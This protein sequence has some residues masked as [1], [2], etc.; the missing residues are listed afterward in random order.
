[1]SYSRVFSRPRDQ[2]HVFCISCIG[3]W[4]MYHCATW[5]SF[6]SFIKEWRD[7]SSGS[8]VQGLLT[9][10][11]QGCF[12]GSGGSGRS[13]AELR[14]SWLQ[15]AVR[16]AA[17]LHTACCRHLELSVVCSTSAHGPLSRGLPQPFCTRNSGLKSRCK[18]SACSPLWAIGTRLS[19]EEKGK[20]VSLYFLTHILF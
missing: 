1:M 5:E 6:I 9:G 18:V 11:G 7:A 3:R 15:I 20:K 8:G 4:I 16:G 10:R 12:I 13:S 17:S 19:T 2:T 14:C